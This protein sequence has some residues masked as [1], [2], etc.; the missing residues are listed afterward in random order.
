MPNWCE[1]T[2]VIWSD[3]NDEAA[4]ERF[5]KE[6][7][8]WQVDDLEYASKIA[9]LMRASNTKV[10]RLKPAASTLLP[11]EICSRVFDQARIT[12]L[13]QELSFDCSVPMP[14]A[15]KNPASRQ[16]SPGVPD[17]YNWSCENW[18]TKWDCTEVV[19]ARNTPEAPRFETLK[20]ASADGAIKYDFLS[21]WSP[22]E[23]WVKAV[24]KQYK[25]SSLVFQLSF[26]E[27][28]MNFSGRMRF[29]DGKQDEDRQV[30]Q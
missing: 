4:V 23:A 6:N 26:S 12:N 18:G 29:K 27:C 11:Q 14:E 7:A 1:N 9:F 3:A 21:A 13:V 5:Y 24:A 2:L 17:W 15:V 8:V 30:R 28:G 22:P 10:P 19:F 16:A 20:F 25:D